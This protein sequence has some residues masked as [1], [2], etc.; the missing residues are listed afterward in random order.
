[1]KKP[2]FLFLF[3][4]LLLPAKAAGAEIVYHNGP[5]YSTLIELPAEVQINGKHVNL[6]VAYKQFGLFWMP[7]WNYGKIGYVFLTDNEEMFWTANKEQLAFLKT[8]YKIDIPDTPSIPL[9]QKIGLKPLII[10]ALLYLLWPEKRTRK[11]EKTTPASDT[12]IDIDETDI[13]IDKVDVDTI[14][15]DL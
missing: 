4:L 1:M 13:D 11:E 14:E 3:T 9:W 15:I 7:V 10:F 5:K 8:K 12:D 2:L 6:G